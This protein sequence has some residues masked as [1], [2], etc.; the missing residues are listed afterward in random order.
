MSNKAFFPATGMPDDDWWRVLWPDP[1]GVMSRAGLAPGMMVID[2]CCGNGHFTV[3]LA[4]LLGSEGRI[5][6]VDME[7]TMLDEAQR[8]LA[9]SSDLDVSAPCAWVESDAYHVDKIL[10]SGLKADAVLMANTF[11]GVPEQTRLSEAVAK[12]LSKDG[13][14]II[15]NWHARRR[16]ETVIFDQPRGPKTDMRMSPEQVEGVVTP[17]GF[18]LKEVIDLPPYHYAS[19]FNIA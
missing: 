3:P 16:E 12:V 9:A 5:V 18:K 7:P 2:L 15:I 10:D 6:A 1:K 19:V 17:A 4:A 14:F 11:H 13:L 8:R